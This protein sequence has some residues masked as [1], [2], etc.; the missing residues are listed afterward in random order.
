MTEQSPDER[1]DQAE[2]AEL[3]AQIDQMEHGLLRRIDPGARAM[4][5]AVCVLVLAVG[6]S[7]CYRWAPETRNLSLE[8]LDRVSV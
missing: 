4:V 7:V 1:D 6:A 5:I 8:A 3:R 2:L